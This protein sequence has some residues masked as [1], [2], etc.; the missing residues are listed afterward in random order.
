MA[1]YTKLNLRDVN[2][3]IETY[4]IGNLL[5]YH[6]IKQGIENTNYFI[7]TSLGKFILTIFE[8]RVL[9]KDIPFFV[10]I[11]IHLKKNNFISPE[12]IKD[13]DGL[14]IKNHQNK[15]YILVSFLEGHSKTELKKRDCVNIGEMIGIMHKKFEG[16]DLKRNNNLSTDAWEKIFLECKDS[17]SNFDLQELDTNLIELITKTLD[18]CKSYWPN[19]LPKGIIHGDLFPD[20]IFFEKD[21]VIGIIDFYFSCNEIRFYEI[22]IALNALCFDYNHKL[23]IEKARNLILGYNSKFKIMI[24]ELNYINILAKG[25]SL[26]F[27]LTRLYDWFKTPEDGFVKKKDPKEYIKKLNYFNE[28]NLNFINDIF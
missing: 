13:Q 15:K 12:P 10:D 8:K 7:K 17:I 5:N 24:E 21:K 23:N 1:V 4:S 22:A 25:A 9:T 18:E 16:T 19:H 20:N 11:M 6:G 3:I 28:N 26:R 2:S 27:L 14:I